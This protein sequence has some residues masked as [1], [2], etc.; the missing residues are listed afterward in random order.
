[1][2]HTIRN[3]ADVDAL[4]EAWGL[5]T[6]ADISERE[7]RLEV[8]RKAVAAQLPPEWRVAASFFD[9]NSKVGFAIQ[10]PNGKRHGVLARTFPVE[11][12][13]LADV[14]AKLRAS[15]EAHIAAPPP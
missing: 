11:G 1:M 6:A 15:G 12:D 10:L 5:P 9:M 4:A 3:A 2:R 14:V 13:V 7:L 8:A